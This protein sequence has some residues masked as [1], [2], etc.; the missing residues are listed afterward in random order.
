MCGTLFFVARHHLNFVYLSLDSIQVQLLRKHACV[1]LEWGLNQGRCYVV[2][3]NLQLHFGKPLCF[4]MSS[5]CGLLS[6]D[7]L[8]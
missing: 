8:M 6:W 2:G 3:E 5:S 1:L 7:R 4:F